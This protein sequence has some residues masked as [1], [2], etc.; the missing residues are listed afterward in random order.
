[1][2]RSIDQVLNLK[3]LDLPPLPEVEEIQWYPFIDSN[4]FPAYRVT[5]LLRDDTSEAHRARVL[6]REI[7]KRIEEAL[8]SAN[9]E[10][11][12]Y[13]RTLTRADLQEAEENR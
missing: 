12:P 6:T 2:Q 8:L 10:E 7:E 9:I 5:V 1:M 13:I 3:S 11:F 4:G